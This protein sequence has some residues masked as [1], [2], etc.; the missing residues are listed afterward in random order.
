MA[1]VR[2]LV[3]GYSLLHACPEVAPGRAPHSQAA[4][5]ELIYWLT[6]YRDAIGTPVTVFFD[7]AGGTGG[8]QQTAGTSEVEVLYSKPGQTADDMIERTAYRLR[9][10]GDVLVVTDDAAERETVV[11]FG[12]FAS[13]CENF[14]RTV[15]AALSETQSDLRRHN[16]REARRFRQ[17][18]LF[19]PETS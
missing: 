7:G 3:D 9:S 15:Q 8:P 12:S 10:Y 17:R 1:L 2:I 13:N 11:G 6:Q 16:Q 18:N 14:F 19:E 5:E 4:R